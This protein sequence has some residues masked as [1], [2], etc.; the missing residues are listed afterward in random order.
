[1]AY[2]LN[3]IE[4][5]KIIGSISCE[6]ELPIIDLDG[7]KSLE[8][9]EQVF[10]EVVP[11]ISTSAFY[12][13]NSVLMV[14]PNKPSNFHEWDWDLKTWVEDLESGKA[15]YLTQVTRE[16]NKRIVLPCNGFDADSISRERITNTILRLQRGDGLPSG[17]VGWR[18]ASNQMHWAT[19][20]AEEVLVHLTDLAR[21]IEN[22]EQALL[23]NAWQHKAAINAMTTLED[24]MN[25]N[26]NEGWNV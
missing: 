13:E 25:Y 20:T 1:M 18:D 19:A 5:G 6:N 3:Y 2:Y 14:A 16:L 21:A 8:V 23:L 22:R 12:V 4:N 15:D 17:W 24:L 10:N 9:T 11:Y 7:L 26:I